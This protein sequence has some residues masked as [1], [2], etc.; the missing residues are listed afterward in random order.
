MT[1]FQNFQNFS[2]KV[3]YTLPF[4]FQQ[5]PW[6]E[7]LSLKL[8]DTETAL[9]FTFDYRERNHIPHKFNWPIQIYTI[10]F[11]LPSDS[12]VDLSIKY[13]FQLVPSQ[14]KNAEQPRGFYLPGAI[15]LIYSKENDE[16]KP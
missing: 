14:N 3:K 12:S 1:R 6:V 9:P 2:K 8:T 7:T 5:R 16:K 4:D 11:E 15:A 13:G 10:E